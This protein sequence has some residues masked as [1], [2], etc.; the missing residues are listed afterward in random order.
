MSQDG[1]L[2]VNWISA[3]GF[4]IELEFFPDSIAVFTEDDGETLLVDRLSGRFF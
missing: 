1:N 4:V 2:I 3:S